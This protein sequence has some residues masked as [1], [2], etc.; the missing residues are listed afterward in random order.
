MRSSRRGK[1]SN[2]PPSCV[3]ISRLA[4]AWVPASRV[5][6]TG[7]GGDTRRPSGERAIPAS[8]R[9]WAGM[10]VIRSPLKTISPAVAGTA[11]RTVLSSVDL[12]APLAPRTVMSSPL[13]RVRSTSKR[14]GSFPYPDR[15][16]VSSSI[17]PLL[18]QLLQ[19]EVGAAQVLG[20]HLGVGGDL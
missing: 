10:W 9:R 16:P 8:T 2:T 19:Q 6:L 5:S 3:P 1:K 12:P 17:D 7:R 13:A 18:P 15:T 4:R 11:P 14:T 20:P